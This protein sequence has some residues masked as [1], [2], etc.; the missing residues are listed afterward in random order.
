MEKTELVLPAGNLEK[1]KYA[2]LYG[3]DAAYCGL[4]DFSIRNRSTQFTLKDLETGIN[5][6]HKIGKKVYITINTYPRNKDLQK[7][8]SYL[9]KLKKLKPDAI[10]LSD[11]GALNLVKKYLPKIKIHLST[12]A[13]TVNVEAVKFWQK[14]G[15]SRIILA[16]E[17]SLSEISEIKKK[18]PKIELEVFVHGAM[19]ISYSGRCLLSMYMTE[20]DANSGECTQPCRW[21]YKVLEEEKRPNEFWSIS[22]DKNGTYIMNS[23]DLCLADWLP[24]L[25]KAGVSAFK[26]EGRAKS[27]YYLAIVAKTYREAI[28]N[29]NA[30]NYKSLAKNFR[31]ELEKTHHRKFTQGFIT[32]KLKDAQEYKTSRPESDWEFCG[33]VERFDGKTNIA[34][35]RVR[36]RILPNTELEFITPS[37][38]FKLKVKKLINLDNKE[39]KA[40]HVDNRIKIKLPQKAE[41]LSVLRQK[42][43]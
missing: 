29:I 2:F 8:E 24:Q 42:I 30:K 16:R 41:V 18:C 37:N 13:N 11:A 15:I 26:I 5:F 25:K 32:G 7:L 19:C 6:A 4:P 34:Q 14:Q 40:A 12:Q 31:K 21:K 3:A 43:Q 28:K 17:L 36:N 33:V 38:Q 22:E 23:K 10:I 20:R 27:I 9:K 35:I 39:L 1:L